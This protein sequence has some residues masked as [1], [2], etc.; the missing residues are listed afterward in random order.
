VFTVGD[1]LMERVVFA[2]HNQS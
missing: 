2:V 1:H